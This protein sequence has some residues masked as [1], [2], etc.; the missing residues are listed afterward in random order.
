MVAQ[1]ANWLARPA[2]AVGA[3][4]AARVVSDDWA[5]EP[6]QEGSC[7]RPAGGRRL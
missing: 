7:E 5:G 3:V 4:L 6:A 2:P 1:P